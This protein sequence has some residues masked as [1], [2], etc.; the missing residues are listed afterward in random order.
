MIDVI[1]PARNEENTIGK[2]IRVLHEHP[3]I[4]TIMVCIDADSRDGT[5][6]IARR[7]GHVTIPSTAG[8]RGKGQLVTHGLKYVRTPYVMFCDSDYTGL[9]YSHITVLAGNLTP[10]ITKIGVPDFPDMDVPPRVIS[11]W[12]WV[13]G[14]RVVPTELVKELALHGY[15]MEVQINKQTVDRGY[16]FRFRFLPGLNSPY[17][18][19]PKRL[20]EMERD[21]YWGLEN[22][23][24]S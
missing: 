14:I 9:S 5:E 10:K 18:M 2:I 21:R 8:I 12:P 4:R 16:N 7:T 22:K 3:F 13:S 15:L 17:K 11:S 19:S 24:L 6:M 23:V 1:V 20:E